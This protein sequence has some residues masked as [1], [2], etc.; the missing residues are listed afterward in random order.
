MSILLRIAYDG[1]ELSGWARQRERPDGSAIRT[2]QG[3]IE[4]ALSRLFGQPVTVRG[5]SRTDAGVHAYGQL[6]AFEPPSAIPARG[7]LEALAGRLPTDITVLAAWEEEGVADVRG[8]NDGKRY[9]YAIRTTRGR[10]PLARDEWHLGRPLDVGAMADA[11]TVLVGRHD[12]SAFRS[13]HCQAKTPVRKITAV[14]VHASAAPLGPTT[15][16][17]RIELPKHAPPNAEDPPATGEGHDR[18]IIEVEGHA[19]LHNMVRII[20]GTLAEVGLGRMDRAGIARL[21][22]D[23]DRRAAGPTAPACGLTLLEVRWGNKV[24]EAP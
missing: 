19:F 10:D 6:A 2:V 23:R 17:G 11:A 16:P 5:A 22:E 8:A 21:L 3:E 15:D 7:V 18:V 20:A 12:F 4:A 9:R 24:G 1:T 13:A 14:R